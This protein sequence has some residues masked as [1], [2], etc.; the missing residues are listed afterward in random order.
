[1]TLLAHRLGIYHGCSVTV[2]Y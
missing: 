1:M 2:Q